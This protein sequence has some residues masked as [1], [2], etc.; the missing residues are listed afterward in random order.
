MVAA[1]LLFFTFFAVA[2]ARP[3]TTDLDFHVH[4]RRADVPKG[5]AYRGRASPNTTLDLRIALVQSNR[6]GLETAL[7][8]VSTPGSS[9]YR[10]HLS[11][12]QVRL[13]RMTMIVKPLTDCMLHRSKRSSRPSQRAYKPSTHGSRRTT[14]LRRVYPR[15]AIGCPYKYPSPKRTP[16]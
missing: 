10:K 9:N 4:E 7:Y 3:T 8:D 1:G 2:L 13:F 15:R 5:F 14:F 6:T 16:C 11:K 12:S